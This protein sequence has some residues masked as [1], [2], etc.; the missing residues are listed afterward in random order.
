MPTIA[1]PFSATH[2]ATIEDSDM[3]THGCAIRTAYG[4]SNPSANETAKLT[5]ECPSFEPAV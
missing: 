1:G 2:V 5:T 4:A 3:S